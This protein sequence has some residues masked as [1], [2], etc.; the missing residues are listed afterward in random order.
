MLPKK[1]RGDLDLLTIALTKPCSLPDSSR[2]SK[3][4]QRDPYDFIQVNTFWIWMDFFLTMLMLALPR[5]TANADPISQIGA[6]SLA[7]TRSGSFELSLDRLQRSLSSST[8]CSCAS[9]L[10]QL[11]FSPCKSNRIKI[12]NYISFEICN[13]FHNKDI[14]ALRTRFLVLFYQ[15][16]I[17]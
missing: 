17:I 3:T 15:S 14:N 6:S 9:L 7:T 1:E 12:K 4:F 8:V 10:Y 11:Y 5:W 16:D 13:F 2:L